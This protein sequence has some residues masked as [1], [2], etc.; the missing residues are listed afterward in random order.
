M[1]GGQRF[2][3]LYDFHTTNTLGQISWHHR[4]MMD[5]FQGVIRYRLQSIH[6]NMRKVPG[7]VLSSRADSGSVLPW[8]VYSTSKQS[9]ILFPKYCKLT[10][11]IIFLQENGGQK[12]PRSPIGQNDLESVTHFY[13]IYSHFYTISWLNE[14]CR[15]F[16]S[17]NNAQKFNG[18]CKFFT[19][20]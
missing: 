12:I 2:L 6:I 16:L 11:F 7:L 18:H 1:R 15:G 14:S 4:Q 19:C 17:T 13:T 9:K 5:N 8:K 3:S 10:S 20:L